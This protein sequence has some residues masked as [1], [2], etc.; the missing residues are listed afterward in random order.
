MFFLFFFAELAQKATK[1]LGQ[2]TEVELQMT[3]F[4]SSEIPRYKI[5]VCILY[6]RAYLT[7]INGDNQKF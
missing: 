5:R 4:T 1:F 6:I 7:N 2:L 3:F